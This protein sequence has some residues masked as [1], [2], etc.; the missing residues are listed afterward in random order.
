[1]ALPGFELL[2]LQY[3]QGLHNADEAC[4]LAVHWNLISNGFKCCGVGETWPTDQQQSGNISGNEVLPTDWR[5]DSTI[6]ALRYVE[7]SSN[8]TF[9]MKALSMDGNLN[10]NFVRCFDEKA[11]SI[12]VRPRDFVNDDLSRVTSAYSN[13][14]DL[15]KTLTHDLVNKIVRVVGVGTSS[16]SQSSSN[17][18]TSPGYPQQQQPQP[19]PERSPLM[20]GP[21]RGP[22]GMPIGFVPTPRPPFGPPMMIDPFG[23][24]R[25][26]LDPFARGGGGMLMDPRAFPSPPRPGF[27]G[28]HPGMPGMPGVPGGL[29]PGAVPPGARFDPIGPHMGGRMGPDPDHER[30]PDGFDDMFM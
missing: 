3:G 13:M 30:P 2:F 11:A 4:I 17:Q 15:N 20:V 5:R 10:I 21:P 18:Q 9:L 23:V 12:S 29:P 7:P 25:A 6:Y 8:R 1:M 24:G 27:P 16:S 14:A 22:G 28:G 26:D 19:Q